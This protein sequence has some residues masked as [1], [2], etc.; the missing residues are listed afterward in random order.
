MSETDIRD[1][2]NAVDLLRAQLNAQNV[3]LAEI[4]TLLSERHG[5]LH[6]ELE[7][8]QTQRHCAEHAE[9]LRSLERI[10]WTTLTATAG[11]LAK[12]AY[13]LFARR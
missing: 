8:I 9:K 12:L 7:E 6:K 3:L 1:L 13:D 11:L 2:W 5:Y 10:V 4:K